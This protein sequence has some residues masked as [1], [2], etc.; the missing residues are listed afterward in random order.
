MSANRTTPLKGFDTRMT[1]RSLLL[2]LPA[3]AAARTVLTAQ[4]SAGTLQI[5]AFNHMTISV[6]D[7]KRSIDFYQ[8]L[9]GLPIQS[10]QGTSST[11]LRVGTGPQYHIRQRGGAGRHAQH[12][13]LL[14]D[15]RQLQRRS[16]PEGARGA[17]RP[18]R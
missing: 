2:S 9:F 10:R 8:G 13:P 1:R 15:C 14:C 5:R 11:Q 18:A 3:I 4:G 12:R 17:R 16:C 7:P 6:S